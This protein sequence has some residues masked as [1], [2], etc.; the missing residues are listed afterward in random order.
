MG[1]QNKSFNDFRGSY[2]ALWGVF[3][4]SCRVSKRNCV[5]KFGVE[6]Q[7]FFENIQCSH[8]SRRVLSQG[9]CAAQAGLF[10]LKCR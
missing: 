2:D 8:G 7:I 5:F 9:T 1:F 3:E 10:L 4:E 6:I